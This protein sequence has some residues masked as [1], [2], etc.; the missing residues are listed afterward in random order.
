VTELPQL[1]LQNTDM[2]VEATAQSLSQNT[3]MFGEATAQSLPHQVAVRLCAALKL[4]ENIKLLAVK[5]QHVP[6]CPI[7]GDASGDQLRT[8]L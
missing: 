1:L 4:T 5:G 6:Q 3:N 7:A 8:V 2:F